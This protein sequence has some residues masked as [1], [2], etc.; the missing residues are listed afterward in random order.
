MCYS[1]TMISPSDTL[2]I[3][4]EGADVDARRKQR[5]SHLWTQSSDAH[6]QGS[7]DA[8]PSEH[9]AHPQQAIV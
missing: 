1:Y 9:R 5:S 3:K 4:E 7:Q 6:I 2:L 8:L